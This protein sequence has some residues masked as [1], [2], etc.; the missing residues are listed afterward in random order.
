[1]LTNIKV[2]AAQRGLRLFEVAA[3]CKIAPSA[4]SEIIAGRR[5]ADAAL[6]SKMAVVL[7]CGE[8]WLFRAPEIPK[9][10]L[11]DAAA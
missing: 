6:R 4:L 7:K 9:E 11:R 2:A 5:E 1:M 3:R 8:N 10:A